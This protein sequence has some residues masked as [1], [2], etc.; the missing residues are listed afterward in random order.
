LSS[1]D[2]YS[3]AFNSTGVNLTA[4]WQNNFGVRT[5]SPM[6]FGYKSNIGNPLPLDYEPKTYRCYNYR[7]PKYI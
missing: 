1:E 7:I 4:Y 2:I 6:V 5:P 3:L